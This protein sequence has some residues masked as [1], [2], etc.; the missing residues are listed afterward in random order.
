MILLVGLGNPEK[1]NGTRHNV[2]FD[3][4]DALIAR[5]NA[6][7]VGRKYDGDLYSIEIAL[8]HDMKNFSNNI[9]KFAH[10]NNKHFFMTNNMTNQS[11]TEKVFLLKP[12]TYMN[13]SGI[14]VSKF[15]KYH[16]IGYH[17]NSDGEFINMIVF[18]DELDKKIGQYRVMTKK[19]SH[20]GLRN[21]DS[22][23]RDGYYKFGI[24]IDRPDSIDQV[25][26]Y[27]L[28]KFTKNERDSV[29]N[30]INDVVRNINKILG[31]LCGNFSG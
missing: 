3:V 20:N 22:H 6:V 30:V 8:D 25:P 10:I 11:R 17:K 1:Y 4:I 5:Y 27:V 26:S 18:H 13:L 15:L 28:S 2:G 14:S 16:K 21:I 12:A 9:E 23:V 19:S 29:D 31:I 24:G 7:F